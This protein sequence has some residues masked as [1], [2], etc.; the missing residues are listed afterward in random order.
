MQSVTINLD[1]VEQDTAPE[2]IPQA[3][4]TG[5]LFSAIVTSRAMGSSTA[6]T[7]VDGV[8][9]E[10]TRY[11]HVDGASWYE[12]S[13]PP[14]EVDQ[15]VPA[16]E[17]SQVVTLYNIAEPRDVTGYTSGLHERTVRA[18]KV[19]ITRYGSTGGRIVVTGPAVRKGGDLAATYTPVRVKVP[20]SALSSSYPPAPAWLLDLFESAGKP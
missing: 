8:D 20:G 10:A 9:Y 5:G 3:H 1:N 7:T 14:V 15:P 4:W 11:R 16:H 13:T 6:R 18:F 2:G 17:V 19:E 12:I